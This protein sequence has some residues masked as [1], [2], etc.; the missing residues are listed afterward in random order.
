MSCRL[1]RLALVAANWEL[2]VLAKL[3]V[4]LCDL[5]Q[6]RGCGL[7]FGK[8]GLGEEV[9]RVQKVGSVF[10]SRKLGRGVELSNVD[11]LGL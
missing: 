6:G 7:E 1:R 3:C 11:A 8:E 2:L 4:S 9:K 10:L 5:V